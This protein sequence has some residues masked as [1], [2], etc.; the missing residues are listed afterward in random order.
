MVGNRGV[1]GLSSVE[2]AEGGNTKQRRGRGSKTGATVQS[3]SGLRDG[4]E[5][6]QSR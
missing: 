4:G 6:R 1:A 5:W 2:E 3:E